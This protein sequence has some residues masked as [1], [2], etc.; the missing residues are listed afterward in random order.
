MGIFVNILV[1]FSAK[2]KNYG[3]LRLFE[4]IQLIYAVTPMAKA[5]KNR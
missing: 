2:I 1:V 5:E 4:T 3:F